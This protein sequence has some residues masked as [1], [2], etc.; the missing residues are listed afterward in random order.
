NNRSLISPD[1]RD[2]AQTVLKTYATSAIVEGDYYGVLRKQTRQPLLSRLSVKRLRSF[3]RRD[4][5]DHLSAFTKQFEVASNLR[6]LNRQSKKELP[7]SPY[8]LFCLHHQPEA[9]TSL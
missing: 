4:R 6:W 8:V 2:A 1:S 9:A 7:R 5:D 3:A